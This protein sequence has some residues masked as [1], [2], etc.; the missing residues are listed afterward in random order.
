MVRA[1]QQSDYDVIYPEGEIIDIDPDTKAGY[2]VRQGSVAVEMIITAPGGLMTI[3]LDT[4]EAGEYFNIHSLFGFKLEDGANL[5][6]RT[7]CRTIIMQVTEDMLPKDSQKL[8]VILRSFMQTAAR[9]E[10]KLRQLTCYALQRA[11]EKRVDR[12][13]GS[14]QLLNKY[15]QELEKRGKHIA[16]L[17]SKLANMG[18]VKSQSQQLS[19]RFTEIENANAILRRDKLQLSEELKKLQGKLKAVEGE[20]AI[21]RRTRL[22]LEK[23]NTELTQQIA[24]QDSAASSARFP[25]ANL[26]LD[27]SEFNDLEAS[28]KQF[29]KAA[30][31]FEG[32]SKGLATMMQ[33]AMELLAQDNPGMIVKN[34]VMMLMTGEEPAPRPSVEK[35]RARHNSERFKTMNLGSESPESAVAR[36]NPKHKETDRNIMHREPQNDRNDEN[37]EPDSTSSFSKCPPLS[38]KDI[39]A[40]REEFD[41]D[42][43]L[44]DPARSSAGINAPYPKGLHDTWDDEFEPESRNT[45][46]F[47]PEDGQT[48]T[49]SDID[50]PP[51]PP[52]PRLSEPS[53]GGKK[54]Q[55]KDLGRYRFRAD[56][57][58]DD[59]PALEA[60]SDITPIVREFPPEQPTGPM[61][62]VSNRSNGWEGDTYSSRSR[63]IELS[64]APTHPKESGREYPAVNFRDESTDVRE[65]QEDWQR[66]LKDKTPPAD[67]NEFLIPGSANFAQPQSS[68]QDS[69]IPPSSLR[70]LVDEKEADPSDLSDLVDD[71]D[72]LIQVTEV[73]S[74]PGKVVCDP[75]PGEATISNTEDIRRTRS[76]QF[77]APGKPPKPGS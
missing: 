24:K 65:I 58:S 60:D 25:S 44:A 49:N 7:Q 17:E 1:F 51:A 54:D 75:R 30:E 4:V 34:D 9:R 29:K 28:A 22:A 20:L 52:T 41:V 68:A 66:K 69:K 10:G 12:G 11:E 64:R 55:S 42:S 14:S 48:P 43:A 46:P 77:P 61:P 32:L 57:L 31:Y 47:I 23:R 71:E 36:G 39:K 40:I 53:L 8:A 70:D 15:R 76:Y 21:E 18:V 45:K 13:G 63:E 67:P 26:L 5:R 37:N 74:S 16:E 6:Y 2:I 35:A 59:F 73:Y 33:R 38:Q 56:E 72:E 3:G 50:I 19:T 62:R 27:S